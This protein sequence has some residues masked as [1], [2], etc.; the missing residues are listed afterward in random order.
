MKDILVAVPAISALIYAVISVIKSELPNNKHIPA[1]NCLA[2][3]LI[4]LIYALTTGENPVVYAWAGLIAALT[5][6][7]FYDLT[8]VKSPKE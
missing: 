5:A 8:Q 1:I 4:G 7:G 2:G 3:I 6:S